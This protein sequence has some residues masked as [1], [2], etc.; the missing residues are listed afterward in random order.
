M[1]PMAGVEMATQN[2]VAP[3]RQRCASSAAV[4]PASALPMPR[5]HRNCAEFPCCVLW[6]V[7][8]GLSHV[9]PFIGHTMITDSK[10]Q[11]YDFA[12]WAPGMGM[13]GVCKNVGI[14]GAPVRVLKFE[15]APGV[16]M[17]EFHEDWDNA[18]TLANS[19]FSKQV[20][21][22]IVNNCHSHV[23]HAL[24]ASRSIRL[25]SIHQAVPR[26]FWWNSI[27]LI[28][29]VVAFGRFIPDESRCY[30]L[31]LLLWSFLVGLFVIGWATTTLINFV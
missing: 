27:M 9:I 6:S 4:E 20:H 1:Q 24:N 17:E 28:C 2:P 18:L 21:M 30:R 26:W 16:S 25:P 14:F 23:N 19:R 29:A 3:L 5:G 22:A 15:A 13:S 31:W 10:G 7:I 8:P 11:L 12:G